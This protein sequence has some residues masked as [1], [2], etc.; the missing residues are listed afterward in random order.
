[1][2]EVMLGEIAR[3]PT[4]ELLSCRESYALTAG[5]ALGMIALGRGSDAAGL[6]DLRIEDRLCVYIH[7]QGSTHSGGAAG[8]SAGGQRWADRGGARPSS[9]AARCYRIREGP[10]VNVDVTAAGAV[11]ALGLIFAKS[12]NTSVAAQLGVLRTAHALHSVRPGLILLRVVARN[13]I[14]W[15]TIRPTTV[16]LESQLTL[17]PAEAAVAPAGGR[18]DAQTLGLAYVNSRAGACLALGLRF[19]GSASA[20]T[21][22]LLIDQVQDF[23]AARATLAAAAAV[24]S[25]P[26][27]RA[28]LATIE[29]CLGTAAVALACVMAG[30]G[31]RC[32]LRLLRVLRRRA[33]ADVS[34][35]FHMS[36]SMA[37]GLLFLGGGRLTL[38]TSKPALA[39]LVTALFPRYPLTPMDNRYHLQA[40]RHLYVL[41]AEVSGLQRAELPGA[42]AAA[43][44][45]RRGRLSCRGRIHSTH[46]SV[47]A[48]WVARKG[49]QG[50]ATLFTCMSPPRV[51]TSPATL[52]HAQASRRRGPRHCTP[53]HHPP[54]PSLV[55]RP[56][57]SR[58]STWTRTSRRWCRCA[59]CCGAR[60]GSPATKSTTRQCGSWSA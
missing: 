48:F 42:H 57:A 4:N 58:L 37:I 17:S 8:Y 10:G 30:T 31:D 18:A 55:R 51:Y 40:F 26:S 25:T 50:H 53:S 60:N 28:E 2:T 19:A 44:L 5:L 16:W 47:H 34:Y 11:L 21:A 12:G 32:V 35:G 1:M 39:A 7:G 29:T 22:Q 20:P 36:I 59:F 15:D 45:G 6:A 43:F 9:H 52:R 23:E 14:L 56:A 54:P 46:T 41:A 3:P 27:T 49:A 24:A 33:D 38:G 13:L